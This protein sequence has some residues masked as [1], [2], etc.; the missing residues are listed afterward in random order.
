MI[1]REINSAFNDSL[2]IHLYK[3]AFTNFLIVRDK[4]FAVGT[5][6]LQDV[7]ASDFFAVWIL[8]NLHGQP[9]QR[10]TLRAARRFGRSITAEAN[11]YQPNRALLDLVQHGFVIMAAP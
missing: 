8:I 7:T 6:H 9:L 2:I 5:T 10:V 3:V 11:P 4:V 1:E